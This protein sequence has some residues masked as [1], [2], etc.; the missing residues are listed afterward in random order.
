MADP[1]FTIANATGYPLVMTA[2]PVGEGTTPTYCST[3]CSVD[4][5][6][7]L[8]P[9]NCPFTL[10][11]MDELSVVVPAGSWMY[12]QYSICS[13][14]SYDESGSPQ[15]DGYLG[16]VGFTFDGEGVKLSSH[17]GG[18]ANM[19]DSANPFYFTPDAPVT[20][21]FQN[22]SESYYVFKSSTQDE[23]SSS[24]DPLN[25]VLP[26]GVD[27]TVNV[28]TYGYIDLEYDVCD[29]VAYSET[30]VASCESCK[31]LGS[32]GVTFTVEQ[33]AE[34]S[35]VYDG[36][37]TTSEIS[38]SVTGISF[39]STNEPCPLGNIIP[40][41]QVYSSLPYRG[42]NLAGCDFEE[43]YP[44]CACDA[45]YFVNQ[46]ASVFR[47]PV[48]WE[49]LQPGLTRESEPAPIDFTKGDA[50]V[51]ANLVREL[52][53]AGLYVIIDMHNYMRYNANAP[54]VDIK[55]SDFIIGSD[56]SNALKVEQYVAAWSSIAEE[57]VENPL[58]MF[59]L[60]NEPN[61]MSTQ[62][63]IQNYNPVIAAIRKVETDANVSPHIIH[64]EGN[65]FSCLGGWTQAHP[66]CG[67]DEANSDVFL[68]AN[69][70]DPANNYV[71]HVHEYF[72]EDECTAE[73]AA[74]GSGVLPTCTNAANVLETE[75]FSLFVEY[76]E[77]Y[78]LKAFLG[79]LNGAANANCINCIDN[80]LS[81]LEGAAYSEE[82][83][84]GFI[85]WTGWAGGS[86]NSDYILNLNPTYVDGK[87][88][89]AQQM[90]DAFNHHMTPID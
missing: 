82:K 39:S 22:T 48:L 61:N 42:V 66:N 87:E 58:V 19:G 45:V 78:K 47:L 86:F 36:I 5:S 23:L 3:T 83:G 16:Y 79:E 55:G 29:G 9:M 88:I 77:K 30:G 40:V 24:G 4:G 68:P 11:E 20:L 38:E 57:F 72:T 28:S 73:T 8:T 90:L 67:Y 43:F 27:Q 85:G 44:P 32:F 71:I 13:S 25:A 10:S 64:L 80:F 15:C 69:I 51:Y 62:L 31:K 7:D 65:F 17:G 1:C 56:S 52:T 6:E 60:M 2:P 81:A 50:L 89:E 33:G 84:Y 41:P 54:G 14:V 12:I 63:I 35:N 46:G 74:C 21:G 75:N 34:V 59:D 18:E 70:I 26:P 37:T 76:L 53:A 49:Y